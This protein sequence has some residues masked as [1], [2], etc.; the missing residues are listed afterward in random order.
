MD[1]GMVKVRLILPH[2]MASLVQQLTAVLSNICLNNLLLRLITNKLF[3]SI[4]LLLVIMQVRRQS[5]K[6]KTL[7]KFGLIL[8]NVV[9][10]LAQD[11]LIYF[12]DLVTQ[13]ES[14]S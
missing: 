13:R 8:I 5:L 9:I 10:S 2:L 6:F 14:N 4:K 7:L 11:L 1:L 12:L 3:I